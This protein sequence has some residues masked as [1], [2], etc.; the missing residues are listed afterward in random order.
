V[1]LFIA[2]T[3]GKRI[4]NATV[5]PGGGAG[6]TC[7]LGEVERCFQ[8]GGPQQ[9]PLHRTVERVQKRGKLQIDSRTWCQFDEDVCIA[10]KRFE[11]AD[12]AR[13]SRSVVADAAVSTDL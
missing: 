10:T 13:A 9:Q 8:R 11:L 5:V 3:P 4:V 6:M 2:Q 1:D 12:D 7:D